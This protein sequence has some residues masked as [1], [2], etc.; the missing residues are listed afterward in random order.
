MEDDINTEFLTPSQYKKY[1][2]ELLEIFNENFFKNGGMLYSD[3]FLIK[4]SIIVTAR[5]DKSLLMA[6]M[7]ISFDVENELD[8]R[9]EVYEEEPEL[10]NSLVI[11]HLVVKKEYRNLNIATRLIQDIKQYAIKNGIHNLYLWTTPDNKIALDFY[12]K[13]GFCKMG[14]YNPPNGVFQELNN[15]HSIMMVCKI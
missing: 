12:N 11:K 7:A 8:R 2:I 9:Y 3:D 5:N 10:E 13:S 14:E 4:S 6:Y 1:K 15:F